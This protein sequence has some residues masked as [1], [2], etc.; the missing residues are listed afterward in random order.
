MSW[1][2]EI[3]EIFTAIP[4]E[5]TA[6]AAKSTAS[7]LSKV[8]KKK[9]GIGA[10]GAA[11]VAAG[12][13][14]AK[15]VHYHINNEVYKDGYN[16]RGYDPEGYDKDGYNS[17][18][19]DKEGYD[20]NGLDHSGFD[21][22]G[23]DCDGYDRDGYDRDG[24]DCYGFNRDGLNDEGY[25]RQGFNVSGFNK[26]GIDRAK[27]TKEE[28]L[29]MI[30]EQENKLKNSYKMLKKDQDFIA[31][32][33]RFRNIEEKICKIMISHYTGDRSINSE[34]SSIINSCNSIL[35]SNEIDKLHQVRLICNRTV[36]E[37]CI[38]SYDELF[39]VYRTLQELIE[40]FK[41]HLNIV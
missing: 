22:N 5:T 37:S 12:G 14:I 19:Y 4:P 28:N 41:S 27:N 38:A 31:S 36:H 2:D 23:F 7:M 16:R 10:A 26:Y 21:Q 1:V 35:S 3:I 34:L 33:T 15:K 29:N 13:I 17:F 40:L 6:T 24:F 25:D 32:A 18:G 8:D 30:K 39:F 20:R 9:L 11:I